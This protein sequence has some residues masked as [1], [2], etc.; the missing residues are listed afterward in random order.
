MG[1][2]RTGG[3]Y[4]VIVDADP[5]ASAARR[6]ADTPAVIDTRSDRRV[7]Y[8]ELDRAVDQLAA[9]LADCGVGRGD[10]IAIVGSHGA[11]MV[12]MVHAVWRRGACIAPIDPTLPD[13]RLRQRIRRLEA[14]VTVTTDPSGTAVADKSVDELRTRGSRP[15]SPI[16]L[17]PEDDACVIFTTG[18]TGEPRAVRLTGRNLQ[19]SAAASGSRLGIDPTDRWLVPLAPHHIGGFGPIVRTALAG[20]TLVIADFDP[21]ALP[22][23]IDAEGVT[24]ASAVPTMLRRDLDG[25]CAFASLRVLL[26]GGDRTPPDLAQRALRQGIPLYTSYGM[27][28]ASSQIATAPPRVLRDDPRTVG[29]PVRFTQVEIADVPKDQ[30]MGEVVV[31]GPTVS[32]G[33]LGPNHRDRFPGT[34]TLHTGDAG[35]LED[36]QLYVGGRI[37]ERIVSGGVTVDPVRVEN[38][39]REHPAVRDVTVIGVPDPEWGERVCALVAGNGGEA[40]LRGRFADRLTAAERPREIIWTSEL[41][42]TV[43]G[44]VDREAA[45]SHFGDMSTAE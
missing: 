17:R 42:R 9:G 28:E 27:T 4:L 5:L 22:T 26:V 45:R 1:S 10:R 6:R 44:T 32:P 43:S 2:D 19:A 7:R 33:Y 8:G 24:Q 38:V 15:V 35:R 31:H 41:P 37:D 11:D 30:A 16:G 25:P 34:G 36:G 18:T 3:N 39:L 20:T 13:E 21:Q 29:R 14:T 23:V 40:D 12:S